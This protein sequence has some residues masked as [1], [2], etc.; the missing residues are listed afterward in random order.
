M[1]A[2]TMHVATREEILAA[3]DHRTERV[4]VPEWG[5]DTVV[6][7]RSLSGTDR[8]RLEGA[9]IIWEKM[10]N[11]TLGIAGYQTAGTRARLVAAA[12][13]DE[14]G[15]LLFTEADVAA[16]GEKDSAPLDRVADV[17][18]RL[19]GMTPKAIEEA[20]AHLKAIPSAS[21]GSS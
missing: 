4:P 13:C 10:P 14:D 7:V 20:K 16:L 21:N 2:K 5:E 3:S 15:R 11:G 8:D 9:G 1:A 6:I 19:S 18:T 12:L 17:A